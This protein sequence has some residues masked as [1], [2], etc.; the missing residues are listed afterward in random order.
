MNNLSN[1]H[2]LLKVSLAAAV[3][4]WIAEFKKLTHDQRAQIAKDAAQVVAEKGD[5]LQF[6]SKT[7]GAAANA[8]NQLARGIAVLAFQPGG[9]TAF[10]MHFEAP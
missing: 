10:G 4:L 8:F 2:E 1:N 7:K 6:G 3:P 9:I 5:V